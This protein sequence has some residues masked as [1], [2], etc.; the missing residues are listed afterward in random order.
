MN[1]KNYFLIGGVVY[2]LLG[3]ILSQGLAITFFACMIG[4]ALLLVSQWAFLFQGKWTS[5]KS[6]ELDGNTAAPIVVYVKILLVVSQIMA[7]LLAI[8]QVYLEGFWPTIVIL[9]PAVL[10]VMGAMVLDQKLLK[11]LPSVQRRGALLGILVVLAICTSAIGNLAGATEYGG[12]S[13]RWFEDLDNDIEYAGYLAQFVYPWI[14]LIF[15]AIFLLWQSANEE[16]SEKPPHDPFVDDAD[17]KPKAPKPNLPI[18][19]QQAL[20]QRKA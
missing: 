17:P 19:D 5:V 10:L 8:N 9:S 16:S 1:A 4:T 6:Q 18:Q 3:L 20:R 11:R 2:F 7:W 15:P 13:S 14:W 12:Q